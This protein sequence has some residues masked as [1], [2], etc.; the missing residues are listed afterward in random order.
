MILSYDSYTE[1]LEKQ[2]EK[3]EQ[4]QSMKEKYDE[5]LRILKEAI[6]DMQELMKHPEKLMKLQN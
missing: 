2:K 5:E 3:E 6:G 1:T 4:I